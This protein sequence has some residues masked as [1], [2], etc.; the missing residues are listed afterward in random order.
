VGLCLAADQKLGDDGKRRI[1]IKYNMFNKQMVAV[2][3]K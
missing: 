1:A 2:M 3:M